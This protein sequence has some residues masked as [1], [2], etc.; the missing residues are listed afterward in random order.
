MQRVRGI[1]LVD[2]RLR[3]RDRS[4]WF[5]L[6]AACFV[7]W[8]CF[9]AKGS[10]YL[11]LALNGT[12]RGAYSSA[13]VGMTVAMTSLWLTLIGF[14]LVRGSI[15][16]DIESQLWQLL[17][18]TPMRHS[19]YLLAK[20]CSHLAVLLMILVP[21]L[22]VALAAQLLRAEDRHID[23]I[24]L[25]KPVLLLSAPSCAITAMFAV[26]FDLVPALRRS[27]G[28]VAYFCVWIGMLAATQF[29]LQHPLGGAAAWIGDPIGVS[30]FANGIRRAVLEQNG[31]STNAVFCMVCGAKGAPVLIDWSVWR[32]AAGEL[33]GRG[34]W[35]LLAA[36][37]V[38]LAAPL[39]GKAA[40]AQ[41]GTAPVREDR[42]ARRDWLAKSTQRLHR[43]RF[44]ALL[45]AEL[46]LSLRPNSLW[47]WGAM[48]LAWCV[49]LIASNEQVALAIV[50][51]WVLLLGTVSRAALRE[52]DA[53][54]GDIVF[55]ADVGDS[56]LRARWVALLAVSV[57]ANLP[58]LLHSLFTA[59][60]IALATVVVGGSLVTWAMALGMLT[61]NGRTYELL[62]CVLA[63]LAFNDGA[64]LNVAI[65]PLRTALAH[66]VVMLPM[67]AW[68]WFKR[69]RARAA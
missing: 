5:L 23:L 16:R 4:F 39:C 58:A 69:G 67:L 35:L 40:A 20:W 41:P 27:A 54:T 13:W 49:Q 43:T 47:W 38:A 34:F 36:G 19:T 45:A 8:W 61:G 63:Y 65:N 32:I 60:A 55:S 59:P 21:M 33:L 26:W 51:V 44:G 14:Y 62:V 1:V 22:L 18:A 15:T 25:A 50:A 57:L 10:D 53:G 52:L 68:L 66:F 6:A 2:L 3:L 9:P 56:V 24:E 37:G 28:N 11:L 46:Q 64:V 42:P 7:A 48:A 29:S 12:Y 17:D 31:V 30:V